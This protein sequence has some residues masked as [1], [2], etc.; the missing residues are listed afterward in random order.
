MRIGLSP[1]NRRSGA[2]EDCQ[3]AASGRLSPWGLTPEA[4]LGLGVKF[5]VSRPQNVSTMPP[6]APSAQ[7]AGGENR[8][9]NEQKGGSYKVPPRT[10]SREARRARCPRVE[11]L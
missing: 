1:E 3:A 6:P 7:P 9:F 5:I 2:F 10:F 4:S 11:K 8:A